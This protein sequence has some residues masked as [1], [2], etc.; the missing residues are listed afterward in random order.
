MWLF[1]YFNF[2]RIYDVLK[3]KSLCILLNGNINFNENET[4]SKMENPSHSFRETNLVFQVIWESE[5]ERERE[6]ERVGARRIK[7]RAFF[8]PF[9]LSE[10]N[11]FKTCVLYQCTVYWIYFKNIHT[12]TF[13]SQKTLLHTLLLLVFKIVESLQ[14]ILNSTNFYWNAWDVKD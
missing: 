7:K 12:H 6:R 11:F 5:R 8:V 3:S 1:N 9:I 10:E 13:T 4:E 2:E 14:C